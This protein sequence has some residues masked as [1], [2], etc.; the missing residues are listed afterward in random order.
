MNPAE[1]AQQRREECR[2]EVRTYLAERPSL[3]MRRA[4]IV[5]GVR[6]AGAFAEAEVEAALVFLSGLQQVKPRHAEIGATVSW[7]IT[8]V[9]TLA[10]ERGV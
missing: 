4:A 10:H 3:A 5:R 6:E 1:A 7:Q 8:A 9:G 2:R